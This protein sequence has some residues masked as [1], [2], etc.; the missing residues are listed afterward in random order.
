MAAGVVKGLIDGLSQAEPLRAQSTRLHCQTDRFAKNEAANAPWQRGLRGSRSVII[1]MC[2]F[3][4][5]GFG[6]LFPKMWRQYV[7]SRASPHHLLWTNPGAAAAP[8]L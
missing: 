4:I 2:G 5:E 6:G 7:P 3:L 8:V 1:G